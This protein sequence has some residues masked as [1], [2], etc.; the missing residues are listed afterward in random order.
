MKE[1]NTVS[2]N[3]DVKKATENVVQEPKIDL[4]KELPILKN[5]SEERYYQNGALVINLLPM[6]LAMNTAQ[7]LIQKL[8]PEG[9]VTP[10]SSTEVFDAFNIEQK[11]RK[12]SVIVSYGQGSDGN[13]V[14]NK[15]YIFTGNFRPELLEKI[16]L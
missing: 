5:E 2:D 9:K 12:Y 13:F 14:L 11:S 3:N 1:T 4:A 10:A 8:F 6:D 16:V 7:E 15:F